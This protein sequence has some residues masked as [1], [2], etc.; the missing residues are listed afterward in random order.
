[1]LTEALEKL[2]DLGDIPLRQS[3]RTGL[4]FSFPIGKIPKHL[5][6]KEL[7]VL[8]S[9]YPAYRRKRIGI[10][11][12]ICELVMSLSPSRKANISQVSRT[13]AYESLV[14]IQPTVDFKNIS[15]K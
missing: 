12:T 14:T 2:S 3:I 10:S 8:P 5:Q 1:M 13:S 9:G 7:K 4:G 15:R 6:L 11:K